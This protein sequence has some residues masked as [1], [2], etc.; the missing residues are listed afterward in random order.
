[1]EYIIDANNLAGKLEILQEEDFDVLLIKKIK[2]FFDKNRCRVLL[3]FDSADPMGDK[4]KEGNIEV[5]YTPKDD[6]YTSADDKILELVRDWESREELT[7]VTDDRGLTDKLDDLENRNRIHIKKATDIGKKMEA[8]DRQPEKTDKDELTD[9]DVE[10][11][12]QEL[13]NKFKK[14]GV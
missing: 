12:N 8:R 10:K 13:L 5:I 3:V 9:Q 4:Y 1:M 6:H 11:I 2:E 14:G 7:V